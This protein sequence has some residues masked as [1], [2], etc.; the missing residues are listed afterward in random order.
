VKLLLAL[1]LLVVAAGAEAR[2]VKLCLAEREFL[3]VSSPRFE[4]PGQYLARLAIEKQGDRASFTALPWTRCVASVRSG[5]YDGAIGV[6]ATESFLP[7]TRFPMAGLRPDVSKSIGDIVFVAMRP[8][9]G[10][11]NWNGEHF[12]NVTKPVLYN[13]AARVIFDKLAGLGVPRD[14]GSPQEAQMVAMMLAGRAEIAI[15]R[16]DA[17]VP[18]AESPAYT[19]RIEVLT[20]PFVSTPTYLAFGKSFHDANTAFDE[21]VWAEI[22]HLRQADDWE[23]IA[24]RLLQNANKD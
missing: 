5:L 14:A 10:K 9:G 2:A 18:L 20:R 23:D 24:R 19:G 11:A 16:E 17:V 15:G 21:A 8:M 4:A 1:F 13:P 6:V 12:E 3:P 22:V 7:Y